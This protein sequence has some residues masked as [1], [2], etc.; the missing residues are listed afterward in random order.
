MVLEYALRLRRRAVTRPGSGLRLRSALANSSCRYWIT[1]SIWAGRGMPLGGISPARILRRMMSQP[2]RLV[3]RDAA[4]V[5]G[6]IFS[7]PEAR[8]S[9]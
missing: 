9:L 5:K 8:L 2:S 1:A 6:A 7:P 4:W 3:V